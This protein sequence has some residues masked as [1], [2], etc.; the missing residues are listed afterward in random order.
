MT[1]V[2]RLWRSG[3]APEA[4]EG[5]GLGRCGGGRRRCGEVWGDVG[6]SRLEQRERGGE[7]GVE[8]IVGREQRDLVERNQEEVT[9]AVT[10]EVTEAV[11]EVVTEAVTEV[12]TEA[13]TE[14]V[15]EAVTEE[16]TQAVTEVVA[17]A[18]TEAVVTKLEEVLKEVG[19]PRAGGAPRWQGG[20]RGWRRA[21][22]VL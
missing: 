3:E 2:W 11:T 4:A 18:V 10:E 22:A 8:R 12:V 17:E 1:G 16:V 5:R 7:E 14:E 6:R 15:T 21:A 13:V 9:E 19:A 20:R